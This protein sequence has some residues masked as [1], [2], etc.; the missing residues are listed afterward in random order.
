MITAT[1][2]GGDQATC[3]IKVTEPA[4]GTV[5]KKGNNSYTVTKKGKEVSFRKTVSTSKTLTI[6]NKVKIA[7]ITYKVTSIAKNALKNNKKIT[8]LTIPSNIASI[9]AKAF[10][11]CSK[12]KTI[13]IKTTKLTMKKVGSSAFKKINAKAT[14]KVPK[15]KKST[16]KAILKKKGI[17]G[18]KQRIR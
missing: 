4:K 8:K 16:Y 10:Y 2:S 3:K 9:G 6:P 5:L 17:T 14:I 7:G 18:K 15:K 12:L 1:T 13:T 11:G